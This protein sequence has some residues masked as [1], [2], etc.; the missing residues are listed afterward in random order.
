MSHG[1]EKESSTMLL[2]I[3]F[4]V[5]EERK[6]LK[7]MKVRKARN[8]DIRDYEARKIGAEVYVAERLFL[9]GIEKLIQNPV[10][11]THAYTMSG[12]RIHAFYKS[13]AKFIER[14]GNEGIEEFKAGGMAEGW[15][16]TG[17]KEAVGDKSALE[18][19]EERKYKIESQVL[20]E[21]EDEVIDFLIKI[22][23]GKSEEGVIDFLTTLY[24]RKNC[25]GS[26]NIK[27]SENQM[28][29]IKQETLEWLCAR[30]I[31]YELD[32]LIKKYQADELLKAAIH[33]QR[34]FKLGK[35]FD[36][37]KLRTGIIY[38]DIRRLSDSN[39][40]RDT[41]REVSRRIRNEYP[42]LRERKPYLEVKINQVY[43]SAPQN[44]LST[45]SYIDYVYEECLKQLI[46][47]GI[48]NS[49]K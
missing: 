43:T 39:R 22:Y 34:L 7:V 14:Y 32:L 46:E 18:T 27:L 21:P 41:K 25:K 17:S 44:L 48:V 16:E 5:R 4:D 8:E 36:F 26:K 40:N 37:S 31:R 28:E 19:Q 42:S 2:S 10:K 24:T 47:D 33:N 35:E 20:I 6:I 15:E 13:S 29:V 12:K 1:T 49:D 30:I 23:M 9:M 11:Y 3:S 45:D 38:D